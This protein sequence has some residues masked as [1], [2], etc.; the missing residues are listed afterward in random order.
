M[1]PKAVVVELTADPEEVEVILLVLLEHL[2]K[3]TQAGQV[4]TQKAV[5]VVVQVVLAAGPVQ[6]TVLLM[7]MQME[8]QHHILVEDMVLQV[9]KIPET[10]MDMEVLVEVHSQETIYVMLEMATLDEL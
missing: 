10:I 4:L 9:E 1:Q 8:L 5:A 7:I 2:N 6:A 3:E